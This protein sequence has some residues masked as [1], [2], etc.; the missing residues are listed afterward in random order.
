MA[1]GALSTLPMG[2]LAQDQGI[3]PKTLAILQMGLAGMAASGPSRTPN[4]LGQIIGQSGMAGLQGYQQGLQNQQQQQLF[5]MKM[6]E[7]ARAEEE[8]KRREAAV[9]SLKAQFPHLAG[10]AD[11]DP[12]AAAIRAYPTPEKPGFHTVGKTLLRTDGGTATPVFK[13][14]QDDEFTRALKGAGIQPGTPQ[15]TA[16][17]AERVKKLGTHQP[18]VNVDNRQENEF[19]KAVGREMGQ[20]YAGLMQADFNAPAWKPSLVRQHRQVQR[21]DDGSESRS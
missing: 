6:A 15:W 5:G 7:V 2:A 11:I 17:H 1:N 19:G 4:S 3:D 21:R 13:A 9:A 16:A 10:L 14:E 18:L 12:G 8:R 20:Q